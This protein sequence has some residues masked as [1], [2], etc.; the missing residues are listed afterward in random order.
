[1]AT[2]HGVGHEGC[3]SEYS[4]QARILQCQLLQLAQ[5]AQHGRVTVCGI[6][7]AELGQHVLRF[8]EETQRCDVSCV[9]GTRPS[10]HC[11]AVSWCASFREPS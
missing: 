11:T 6:Q 7:E 4:W 5:H 2:Y 9:S 3:L 1:M 8:A 10:M